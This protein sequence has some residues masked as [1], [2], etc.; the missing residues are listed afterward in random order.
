MQKENAMSPTG[1]RALAFRARGVRRDARCGTNLGRA[2]LALVRS[3]IALFGEHVRSADPPFLRA[4]GRVLARP[5]LRSLDSP[6]C[7]GD[8][9]PLP[10][11]SI[12]SGDSI[13]HLQQG[14]E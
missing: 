4:G 8:W 12:P 2:A 10:K 5:C 11:P 7:P 9:R 3:T 6:T 14:R 13:F 1:P